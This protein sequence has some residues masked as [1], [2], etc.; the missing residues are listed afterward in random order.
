MF[1]AAE[2]GKLET[3]KFLLKRGGDLNYRDNNGNTP[4]HAATRFG[5]TEVVKYIFQAFNNALRF[6]FFNFKDSEH[7]VFA[8][9]T[10][11]AV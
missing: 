2:E 3:V 9:C 6:P 10:N 7:E 5:H 8:L 1:S 11:T 4:L